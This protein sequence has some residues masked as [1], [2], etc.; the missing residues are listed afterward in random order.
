MT[1]CK[2]AHHEE[3]ILSIDGRVYSN[4]SGKQIKPR[5]NQNGYLIVT[6]DGKQCSLHKLVAKHFVPN[7]YDHPQVNHKDGDK[8]NNI[9][10]N[11]EWVTAKENIQHSLK[12]GLRSGYV[13]VEVKRKMMHRWLKGEF[14]KELA[15]E[16]GNHP[17]TL[18][19]MMRIQA[20]KD[21]LSSEWKA[22]AVRKRKAIAIKNLESVNA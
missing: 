20:E 6:L 14:S 5:K 15:E 7:P 10:H 12:A 13:S 18:N 1:S 21:G 2:I 22:E 17:N 8:T 4:K 9:Y 3:Y 19:R 11:L 16:I